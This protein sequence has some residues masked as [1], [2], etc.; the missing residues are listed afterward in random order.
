M[1]RYEAISIESAAELPVR[2]AIKGLL[3]WVEF[4][5]ANHA[6]V[7][8]AISSEVNERSSFADSAFKDSVGRV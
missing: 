6:V 5:P 8:E 1:S 4:E 2:A 7:K 3:L